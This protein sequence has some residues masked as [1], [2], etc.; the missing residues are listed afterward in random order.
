MNSNC[1][2]EAVVSFGSFVKES[3]AQDE[4]LLDVRDSFNKKI[5]SACVFPENLVKHNPLV[6][7]A[8][9]LQSNICEIVMKITSKWIESRPMLDLSEHF[10]DKIIFL[11]YGKVNAGK[12]SFCNFI[13]SL[14]RD[15]ECQFFRVEAGSIVNVNSNFK[16]G[17]TET[18]AEIQGVQLANTL[19]LLDSPGLHSVTDENGDL[20]RR[21]TDAADSVIWL[22]PSS[23]PGQIAELDDLKAELSKN[24]P[25]L[26][27]ISASDSL[28][29]DEID[30]ALVKKWI[31][32]SADT[33]LAQEMDVLGRAKEHL[34]SLATK[35]EVSSPVSISV[36]MYRK[37][38]VSEQGYIN[39]G[40]LRLTEEMTSL[41][42]QASD[43]KKKKTRQQI[44][45]H[46]DKDVLQIIC[47]KLVPL[48]NDYSLIIES[49]KNQAGH[50]VT[51]TIAK[52]K[53]E[54]GILI[55]KWAD[56]FKETKDSKK[57]FELINNEFIRIVEK[58]V[59]NVVAD[60][61]NGVRAT[62]S[63]FDG[64]EIAGFHDI[65]V[66]YDQVTGKVVAAGITGAGAL[67]GAAAGSLLGPVG[68][69]VGSIAGGLA[70]DY[71]SQFVIETKRMT[72]IVGVDT[73]GFVAEAIQMVDV[74]S[75][76][77]VPV[78]FSMWFEAI[79]R[80]EQSVTDMHQAVDELKFEINGLKGEQF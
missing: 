33:R 42:S 23:S 51:D 62:H 29:E 6:A 71:A 39:S 16:E 31:N 11:V 38:D 54:L 14:F 48:I 58:E 72:S 22:T 73:A 13:A 52:L 75:K 32:K 34:M 80:M 46:L 63:E 10:D 26:P 47:D 43:Y 12:S 49:S 60:F 66:E 24:K 59:R 4:K 64:G 74:K 76:E 27:V 28:E 44:V 61:A 41:I 53:H 50:A 30:G 70:A 15:D 67:A 1:L 7:G 68:A 77:L 36:M 69:L 21:F 20:T 19:V 57:I 56:E 8:E 3:E 45:N 55:P 17:V 65:E 35:T 25:L 78:W 40:L 18:T 5:V 37:H 9:S 79:E 2:T